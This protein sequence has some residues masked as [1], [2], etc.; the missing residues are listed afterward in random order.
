ML[1]TPGVAVPDVPVAPALAADVIRQ[2][3]AGI[4]V[5]DAEAVRC[6][7]L[8]QDLHLRLEAHARIRRVVLQ[9]DLAQVLAARLVYLAPDLGM[10]ALAHPLFPGAHG[11]PACWLV[12]CQP[13][14]S[15]HR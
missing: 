7:D 6:D 4:T 3:R 10:V 12:R 11:R 2:A 13:L 9:E 8:R 1:L 14:Q 5:C 15:G